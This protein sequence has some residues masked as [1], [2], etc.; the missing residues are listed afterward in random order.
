LTN[1]HHSTTRP[2]NNQAEQEKLGTD[3]N[4]LRTSALAPGPALTSDSICQSLAINVKEAVLA[5]SDF[6]R[7]SDAVTIFPVNEKSP[8]TSIVN[9]LQVV[10]RKGVEPSTSALRTLEDPIEMPCFQVVFA[11]YP[12]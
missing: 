1:N 4:E 7:P 11:G 10:E 8:L 5:G 9:G 2:S 12:E 3:L 6:T